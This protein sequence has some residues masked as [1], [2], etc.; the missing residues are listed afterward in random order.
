MISFDRVNKPSFWYS[1]VY[2]YVRFVHKHVY[3]SDFKVINRRRLPRT[4][5]GYL[6]ICNHQNGLCDAIGVL[7]TVGG[8]RRPVFIARGDLFKKSNWLAKFIRFFRIM[9]AFR[10]RDD[11]WGGLGQNEAIFEESARIIDEGDVVA[12]F[13]EATHQHGH[14]LANFKKGFARIA[15]KVVEKSNFT[16]ALKIVPMAH[17]YSNYFSAREK[18][19]MVVGEPFTFTELYDLYREDPN[20]AI[21]QLNQKAH[22]AVQQLMLDIQDSDNY[23]QY[24][25][26]CKMGRVEYLK[27]HHLRSTNPSVLEADKA[28]VAEIDRFKQEKPSEFTDLMEKVKEYIGLLKKVNLRDWTLRRM[29][30]PAFMG[31]ALAGLLL[32]PFYL[33]G[34]VANSVPLIITNWI[35]GSKMKD[36]MLHAS[37]RFAICIFVLPVWYLILF[38]AAW[39]CLPKFWMALLFAVSLYPTLLAFLRGL[40]FYPK[41]WHRLRA[42]WMKFRRNPD[43]LR[44]CDV[45][46]DI[47]QVMDR[48][49]IK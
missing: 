24:Y 10:V 8:G 26:L 46:R 42:S 21:A 17:H 49:L 4:G 2:Q 37:V 34:L 25:T 30:F 23:D 3:F 38:V 35:T 47:L 40:T 19:T 28:I 31:R 11:G 16:K 45:R 41:L 1:I 22:D 29:L 13:P 48:E 36:R 43:L 9:P 7:N 27:R 14:Y 39:I 5:E 32:L 18:Q 15:F 44:A 33:Y 20:K 12:L 6:V